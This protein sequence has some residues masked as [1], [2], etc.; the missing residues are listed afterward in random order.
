MPRPVDTAEE[1]EQVLREVIPHARA[2]LWASLCV[3]ASSN[4]QMDA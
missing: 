4:R 3:L 1:A 2:P